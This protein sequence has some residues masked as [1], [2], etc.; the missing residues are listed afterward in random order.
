MS[1]F[2]AQSFLAFLF[3]PRLALHFAGQAFF[4][5]FVAL[6]PVFVRHARASMRN[7]DL[8]IAVAFDHAHH[9]SRFVRLAVLP[10]QTLHG[11]ARPAR[12]RQ[13]AGTP[14]HGY[15]LYIGDADLGLRAADRLANIG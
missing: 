2:A 15:T 1:F 9:A 6:L 12:T 14:T 7:A 3:A 10:A 4:Q 13:N 11:T 5:T 8:T